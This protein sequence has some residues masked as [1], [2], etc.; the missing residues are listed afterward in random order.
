[1]HTYIWG[2]FVGTFESLLTS[3]SVVCEIGVAKGL[4]ETMCV[5]IEPDGDINSK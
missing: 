1:M 3:G 2:T 5:L 4:N